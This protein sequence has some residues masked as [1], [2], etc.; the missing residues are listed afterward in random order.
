MLSLAKCYDMK[1]TPERKKM[2]LRELVLVVVFIV[3]VILATLNLDVDIINIHKS[4]AYIELLLILWF[5]IA[6]IY[7]AASKGR[8]ITKFLK[9]ATVWAM[10]VFHIQFTLGIILLFWASSF[11]NIIKANG[12]GEMMKNSNLRFQFIEHPS[13]MTIAAVLMTIMNRMVR[14]REKV[15]P[16]MCIISIIALILFFYVLPWG[17]LF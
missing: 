9:K 12:M 8:V 4:F 7:T 2:L 3:A 14:H 16:V 17:K 10:V 13:S 15:A 11:L 1:I 5:I 6:L